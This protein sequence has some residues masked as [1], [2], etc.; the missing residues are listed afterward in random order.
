VR[1]L[2]ESLEDRNLLSTYTVNALTDT[3]AG[4]GQT[5]DLRYCV[6]H[7]TSGQD[8]I[9][10]GVTGTITLQSPLPIMNASVDITGPGANKMTVTAVAP[11]LSPFFTVGNAATVQISGLTL[12]NA[13]YS[14]IL[15]NGSVVASNISFTLNNDA[16]NDYAID[17]Q[18]S[19][20][21]SNSSFTQNT[22]GIY[23]NGTLDVSNCTFSGNNNDA[24][25][26]NVSATVSNSTISGCG[27][28]AMSNG[29]SLTVNSCTLSGNGSIALYNSQ[30][31]KLTV[32]SSTISDNANSGIY[33][34]GSASVNNSTLSGNGSVN[35]APGVTAEGGAIYM[36]GGKLA[37]N[38]STIANNEVYGGAST[39]SY[40]PSGYGGGTPAGSGLGGGLYIAAGTV[41]IDHSTIANNQALA[42]NPLAG[43]EG[44]GIYNAAGASALQMHDTILA[45]NTTDEAAPDLY[46][47]VTSLGYNLIGN[48][49]GGS[50]FS[51][52][53][54]LNVDPKLGPLQNN[55]GSTQ[56]MA[57]PAGS[58]AVN[59]GDPADNTNPNTPAY[60]QR[61]PGFPRIFGGRIDIG[62]FEVQNLSGLVVSGFPTTI[63]AGATTGNS[64]TV[65]ARNADGTTETGYTGTITLSSTD[66]TATFADAT[67]GTPL[68]GD[69]YTFQPGDNGTHTFTA[70][71]TKAGAQAI[72]ATDTANAGFT[73][74]EGGILVE[75]A[76]ASTLIVAGY[77][78]PITATV[79][80]SFT[81]TLEDPYGNIASGYT[82]TVQ[83]STSD[84]QAIL[85]GTTRA[86]EGFTYAFTSN[87]A[88]SHTFSATFAT[89]GTQSITATDTA[90]PTL[91]GTD[92]GI[93][94]NP[95]PASQFVLTAPSSATAGVPFSVTVTAEDSFGHTVTD[96]T[97]TVSISSNDYRAVL[98]PDYTFTAADAGM[99][100]FSVTLAGATEVATI[101][102][103]DYTNGIS[104]S[105]T[106][107]DSPGAISKM[108]VGGFTSPATA[109]V[110]ST[111][112]VSLQDAYG[113]LVPG[114]TGTVQ[115]STSDP[116]ATIIDP[117]T[118]NTVAL[119]GF[120]YTFTAANPGYHFFNAT[121]RTAGTQSITATDTTMPILTGT[122]TGISVK[123]AA[124]SKFILTA[125]ASVTAGQ[126]FSLTV[127]VED[128]YG[129]AVTG[130]SG[131]IHFSNSDRRARLPRNYTFTASEKGVHTFT[132]LVL[133]TQGN[134]K[135]TVTDTHNSAL[136]DSAIVN[137][138]SGTKSRNSKDHGWI[139]ERGQGSASQ[140]DSAD[141][142]DWELAIL[143][144]LV[145]E[146]GLYYERPW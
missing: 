23:N 143:P 30:N 120:S 90:T 41:T 53:D 81:V 140:D 119:Q 103:T 146:E 77:P 94:V 33:N 129:N 115:F 128:A 121:L 48:T 28:S 99:R 108:V 58:P 27:E 134:Q 38:N 56:T 61:G 46:G 44:G 36:G 2:L 6:T 72:T 11:A 51:A 8:T 145:E 100:T 63:L 42:T 40:S 96:Y 97:G 139:V 104:G 37:I 89:A 59:A 101:S 88:G 10:F 52:S 35:T 118:G 116:Q 80:G 91:T 65:T 126:S 66:P 92:G 54:L 69:S 67:T 19:A 5:G 25:I 135:I 39:F 50:G 16:G 133:Y 3:G 34:G 21:V 75:P 95:A 137:V 9:T 62:A 26:N 17:N 74:S 102:A 109:G 85:T 15:N 93:T 76:A 106:V 105:A 78:S 136:T 144:D 112:A 24:I 29:G 13:E 124:A 47:G 84:A 127:T 4:S 98:P 87:D 82:G 107:T 110:P 71:L 18:G 138:L 68:S 22:G 73:S 131:T 55:G 32:N 1:P 132:G 117:V 57:L 7:A 20:T 60:D 64:F 49:T 125:P 70:V 14:A 111:F 114:Y 141:R 12:E 122:E 113:N 83:F 45:D 142:L 31:G 79:P 130:Y 43:A 86:L 123:P